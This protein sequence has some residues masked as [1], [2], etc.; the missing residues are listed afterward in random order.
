MKDILEDL[1]VVL[2][3]LLFLFGPITVICAC[4]GKIPLSI[5]NS[6]LP[7]SLQKFEDISLK[8]KTRVLVAVVGVVVWI[9]VW[10]G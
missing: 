9:V 4:V 7:Q 5:L 8:G 6:I 1:A 2:V 10:G 3:I